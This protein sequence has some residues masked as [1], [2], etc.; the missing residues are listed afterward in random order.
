VREQKATQIVHII[1]IPVRFER[2]PSPHLA[3]FAARAES[4]YFLRERAEREQETSS[5][6]QPTL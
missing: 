2:S 3:F 6:Y 4:Y 1:L 5:S